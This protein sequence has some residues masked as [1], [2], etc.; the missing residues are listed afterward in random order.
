MNGSEKDM[1]LALC[2]LKE[3][4]QSYD[5]IHTALNDVYDG[6]AENWQGH[7]ASK[8]LGSIE[9]TRAEA[10]AARRLMTNTI[11]MLDEYKESIKTMKH[12]AL[13]QIS[14]EGE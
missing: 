7:C 1:A 12:N 6:I 10:E 9:N 3:I 5:N 8:I 14:S 4:S 13:T 11:Q 2:E